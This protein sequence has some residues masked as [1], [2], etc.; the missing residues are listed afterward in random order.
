M[1]IQTQIS[2]LER[3]KQTEHCHQ[4]PLAKKY[5]AQPKQILTLIEMH[6]LYIVSEHKQINVTNCCESIAHNVCCNVQKVSLK[7]KLPEFKTTARL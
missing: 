5:D 4:Y 6:M 2:C 1:P 3:V 7:D